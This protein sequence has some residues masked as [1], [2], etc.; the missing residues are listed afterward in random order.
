MNTAGWLACAAAAYFVG[1]IPFGVL[2]G[3]LKGVDVRQHGSRNIGATNV[4]RVLGRKW[5]SLCFAL[6]AAKGAI[7]VAAAGFAGGVIGRTAEQIGAAALG[8]WLLVVAAALLGHMFSPFIGFRGGKGVAT[9]FGALVA[10]WP[11]LALPALLALVVWIMSLRLSRMV[12]LA[13]IV[14]ALSLPITTLLLS[15]RSMAALPLVVA[16]VALALLVVVRHHSNIGRILRGEEP[17]IGRRNDGASAA[18][19]TPPASHDSPAST[20]V[21]AS[22]AASVQNALDGRS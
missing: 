20:E 9:G 3:R 22:S 12:S 18:A 15:T 14:A 6:D 1:S 16:T 19:S 13:S 21:R 8:W 5:G 17:R 10:F 7:P 4:G 2:L 11:L